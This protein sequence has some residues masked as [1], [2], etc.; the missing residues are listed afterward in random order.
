MGNAKNLAKNA[1]GQYRRRTES[2]QVFSL[3][4]P[5][6][7]VPEDDVIEK[8][9]WIA[10][11]D[12]VNPEEAAIGN[13]NATVIRNVLAVLKRLHPEQHSALVSGYMEAR[14]GEKEADV[15]ARIGQSY[16]AYKANLF[17]ARQFVRSKLERKGIITPPKQ[18][19]SVMREYGEEVRTL[20]DNGVSTGA[21][22]KQL[23]VDPGTIRVWLAKDKENQG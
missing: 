14:T 18:K 11:E 2:V 16:R 1:V 7:E 10:D 9:D 19:Q 13:F 12:A 23:E 5:T 3:N 8:G 17:Q 4:S 15:A 20:R 22:A 6:S 21:I